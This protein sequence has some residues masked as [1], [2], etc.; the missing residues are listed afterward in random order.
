M[1]TAPVWIVRAHVVGK[2]NMDVWIDHF[3]M[4]YVVP[5]GE[6]Y[7]AWEWVGK[8]RHPRIRGSGPDGHYMFHHSVSIAEAR[9][10]LTE[11]IAWVEDQGVIFTIRPT[12]LA[13]PLN[14]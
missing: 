10:I 2:S 5:H 3:P 7:L 14:R 9:L 8:E 4:P 1:E 12:C 6:R 13:H 11:R